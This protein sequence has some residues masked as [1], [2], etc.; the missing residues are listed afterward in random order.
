[1]ALRA[2]TVAAILLSWVV[3]ADARQSVTLEFSAGKVNLSAQN[4]P[5]RA[6]LAEW[7]RLGGAII[8]NGDRV[9]GPPVTLELDGVSER[10]AL[11]ILLRDVAGYMIAPRPAGSNGAAA[12]DRV[13]ILATS[14][15]PRNPPPMVP[16]GARP[17]LPRPRI[18]ARPAVG[19]DDPVETESDGTEVGEEDSADQ[20][21]PGV[22]RIVRPAIQMPVDPNATAVDEVEQ[23]N[24]DVLA[25]PPSASNPF[26]VPAGSS[27]MPGIVTPQRQGQ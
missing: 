9:V 5:V 27:A 21:D 8:V 23:G 1:M 2:L 7:A 25:V 15:A 11:D 13:V 4:V 24:D 19:S 20:S 16:P 18:L 22:P 14:T 10:Q 3:P 12:F 26:G 6:I 17:T